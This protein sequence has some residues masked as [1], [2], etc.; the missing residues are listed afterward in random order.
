MKR[1]LRGFTLVELLVVIAIIAV[2]IGLLLPAVQAAREAA[3]R[4]QCTNN[5]K[6]LGLAVHNYISQNGVFPPMTNYPTAT[7]L[8]YLP[9]ALGSPLQSSWGVAILGGLE[10]QTVYNAFNIPLGPV[11][12]PNGWPNLTVTALSITTYLCPSDQY[13]LT[14]G[15]NAGAW[16]PP[17]GACSYMGNYGGPGGLASSIPG[18]SSIAN[19][20]IV[21]CAS[22]GPAVPGGI[23]PP[24]NATSFGFEGVTDGSSN[25][26]LFSER[27]VGM[28]AGNGQL[29]GVYANAGTDSLRGSFASPM[30]L[31]VSGNTA[32]QEIQFLQSCNSLP[33]GT[34][35][36]DAWSTGQS[37]AM[38]FPLYPGW[39]NYT[40]FGTPNT[41]TC[42]N[43]G[44]G[45]APNGQGDP[46]MTAPPTSLHPG[47]VNVCTGDGSVHFIKNSINPSPW[48]ALGTRRG[49]EVI[50]SDSY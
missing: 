36:L 23:I 41:N 18:Q 37:W 32:Q 20:L 31:P 13:A 29:P 40:H 1:S 47:G 15:R 25:T 38:T 24:Q 16:G 45:W 11:G 44:I 33:S 4:A 43:P 7:G 12:Y 10:L 27:L 21:P 35:S 46:T 3:R 8:P 42:C 49:G 50:S 17:F 9:N 39:V 5:L 19:G 28:G 30:S 34:I 26:G 2:L 22:S 48:W 14:A 6:Q